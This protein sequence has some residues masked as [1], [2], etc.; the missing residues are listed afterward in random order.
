MTE[1]RPKPRYTTGNSTTWKL[2]RSGG[3]KD[4]DSRAKRAQV[5]YAV[6]VTVVFR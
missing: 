2:K 5:R 4:G 6:R 1:K 3:N